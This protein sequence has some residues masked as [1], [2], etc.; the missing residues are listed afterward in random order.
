MQSFTKKE[1]EWIAREI[2]N[3]AE[4]LKQVRGTAETQLE[5]SLCTLRAEQF[6]IIAEKLSAVVANGDKQIAIR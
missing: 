6:Q 4:R 2:A 5:C 3:A 1:I